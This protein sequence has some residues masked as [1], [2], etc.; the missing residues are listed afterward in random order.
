M[1]I[2]GAFLAEK[3]EAFNNKLNV[4]G[5]VISKY[6]VGPDRTA[7]FDIVVLTQGDTGGTD[8]LVVIEVSPPDGGQPLHMH[9]ELPA[10]LTNADTGFACF[11]FQ[12]TFNVNGRW[13]V[14]MKGAAGEASLPLTVSGP[15]PRNRP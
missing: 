11:Q 14:A 5:G 10:N 1:R 6:K 8:R 13:L 12:L 15:S 4:Q 9:R 2:S 7:Q 3:T